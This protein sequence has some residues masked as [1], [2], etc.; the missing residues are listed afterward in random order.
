MTAAGHRDRFYASICLATLVIMAMAGSDW[1]GMFV[2]PLVGLFVLHTLWLDDCSPIP[3][4]PTN[5]MLERAVR[6]AAATGAAITTTQA[7][8]IWQAMLDE[9]TAGLDD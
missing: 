7:H 3:E 9:W 4:A 5:D 1:L 6:V 2:H 8:D